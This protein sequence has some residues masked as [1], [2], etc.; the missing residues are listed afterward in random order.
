MWG[1]FVFVE[2]F[3]FPSFLIIQPNSP[4]TCDPPALISQVL[5]LLLLAQCEFL[6]KYYIKTS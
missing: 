6:I 4:Q 2:V 1:L 5:G 3:F